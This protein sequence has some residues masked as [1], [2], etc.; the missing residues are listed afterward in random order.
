MACGGADSDEDGLTNA[1]ERDFGSDPKLADSDGD[2]LDDGAEL[3]AGTDPTKADTD[4]DG[5]DDGDEVLFGRDPLDEKSGPYEGGWPMQSTTVKDEFE[6]ACA[7]EAVIRVGTRFPR[8]T[9]KDQHGDKVDLYDFAGHGKKVLIDLSALNCGPCL[10][11][12]EWLESDVPAVDYFGPGNEG[13]DTL[14]EGVNSG[15][16]YWLTFA[17]TSYY[18]P[19]ESSKQIAKQWYQTYPSPH[20]PVFGDDD[21]EVF[22]FSYQG[23]MP[24][25]ALL[26]DK[27]IVKSYDMGIG[28]GVPPIADAIDSL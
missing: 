12:A 17:Y 25:F 13:L 2:G 10:G 1:E 24:F 8:V 28:A 6:G 23:G 9:L 15:D 14:R 19:S 7:S 21:L 22:D 4:G 5:L 26:N 27:M 20:V 18:P 16:I 3:A 11:T